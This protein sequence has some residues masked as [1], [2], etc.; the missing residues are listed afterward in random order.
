M[1]RRAYL[2]KSLLEL[3]E[4][5]IVK[6]LRK[7][8]GASELTETTKQAAGEES[9]QSERKLNGRVTETRW[10]GASLYSLPLAFALA[11]AQACTSGMSEPLTAW[12]FGGT[13][14]RCL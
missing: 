5:G 10:V 9:L 12:R 6:I 8:S 3:F 2:S 11:F 4:C 1:W 14:A 7:I 13:G